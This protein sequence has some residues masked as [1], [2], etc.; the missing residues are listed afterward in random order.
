ME[1]IFVYN[2][3]QGIANKLFDA[4]HKL[5][6]PST[7][8]CELCSLSHHAFG[9]RA[10]W[11][12]FLN[13]TQIPIRVMYQDGFEKEFKE[14][15]QFPVVLTHDSSGICCILDKNE[16]RQFND[17]DEMLVSIHNRLHFQQ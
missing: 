8:A 6:S 9:A 12:K 3:K 15:L 7:Y 17:L 13:E 16:I 2:A 4:G 1:L 10:S 11:K 5:F 14:K